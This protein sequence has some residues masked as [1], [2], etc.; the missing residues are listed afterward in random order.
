A[1]LEAG[2]RKEDIDKAQALLAGAQSDLKRA[3]ETA[4]SRMETARAEM[5]E[6]QARV[7][8]AESE[9]K[10]SILR[11]PIGGNVVWKFK[12][13]GESVGVLPPDPVAALA[14]CSKLRVRASVD[15]ADYGQIHM[16]QRVK[17]SSDSCPGQSFT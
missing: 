13:S 14:D 9:I 6:A 12:H 2:Y 10:K 8:L 4:P 16:G 15:E 3:R 1:A 17:L 7:K 11:A 5:A